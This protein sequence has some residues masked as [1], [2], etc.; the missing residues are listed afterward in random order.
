MERT[1]RDMI[2]EAQLRGPSLFDHTHVLD[3]LLVE[4]P[5]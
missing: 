4:P 2:K 5:L 1:E 3:G